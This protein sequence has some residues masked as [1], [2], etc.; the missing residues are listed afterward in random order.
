MGIF[1]EPLHSMLT[2]HAYSCSWA[3]PV[4]P[5][6]DKGTQD[7]G[8]A[9]PWTEGCGSVRIADSIPMFNERV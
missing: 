3:Q 4:E 7:S 2:F 8:R 1:P 6:G 5:N 9:V